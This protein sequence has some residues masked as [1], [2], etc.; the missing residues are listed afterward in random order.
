MENI[1]KKQIKKKDKKPLY[2]LGGFL[3][4]FGIFIYAITRPSIQSIA[5]K[6]LETSYNTKDVE[7]VWDK[8]KADLSKDEEFLFETRKKLTGFSLTEDEINAC[9]NW[10]PPAPIS[11]N[12]III[13]DLS[14]RIIDTLNNP[15][16]I[17]NDI[18]ILRT[19]WKSFVDF[20]KWG[21]S[22]F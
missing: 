21:V 20:S 1:Q 9:R 2:I 12:L 5:L 7:K 4:F 19:I 6:E 17:N 10:L 18:F 11:I 8:Y 15:D 16:Q 13:P 14:R 3:I 22:I